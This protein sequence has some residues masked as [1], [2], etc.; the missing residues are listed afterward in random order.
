LTTPVNVLER[1]EDPDGTWRRYVQSQ[2]EG[3]YRGLFA[4]LDALVFLAVPSFAAA[5]R[6]RME[7]E[8]ALAALADG[9]GQRVMDPP[10]LKR[11]MQHYERLTQHMLRVLPKRADVT[12]MLGEDHALC[13][14]RW[15]RG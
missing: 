5:F 10:A 4:Q 3:P 9:R 12:A 8:R 13:D 6:W 2:L 15:K 11:F 14:L 7:Q 1:N